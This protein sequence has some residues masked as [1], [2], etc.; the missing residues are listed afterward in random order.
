MQ[1]DLRST[2]LLEPTA[3]S[4]LRMACLTC[5]S[6]SDLC[7]GTLLYRGSIPLSLGHSGTAVPESGCQGTKDQ[8][9][10]LCRSVGKLGA[11]S[12]L[13]QDLWVTKK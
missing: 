13:T 6:W 3:A 5:T 2:N 12:A 7:R 1:H 4:L 8:H 10:V 9:P 11:R